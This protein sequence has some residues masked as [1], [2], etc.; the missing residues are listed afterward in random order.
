MTFFKYYV[1]MNKVWRGRKIRLFE[2]LVLELFSSLLLLVFFFIS[3]FLSLF[4]LFMMKEWR[5][6]TRKG[7]SLLSLPTSFFFFFFLFLF[8]SFSPYFFISS[9]LFLTFESDLWR[10]EEMEGSKILKGKEEEW[11]LKSKETVSIH[12][13]EK[14]REGENS[15]KWFFFSIS[16]PPPLSFPSSSSSPSFILR[17]I[18]SIESD[19]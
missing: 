6:M 7:V 19:G 13:R 18:T 5:K 8:L 10:N 17:H 11:N 12:V 2:Y 16:S 15:W 1:C 3:F 14:E 4:T 9:S